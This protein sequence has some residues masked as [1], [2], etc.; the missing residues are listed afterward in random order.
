MS[1][2]KL[3]DIL[4]RYRYTNIVWNR[5]F[6][7][8]SKYKDSKNSKDQFLNPKFDVHTDAS[9]KIMSQNK[10]LRGVFTTRR[11]TNPH[12]PYLTVVL[13]VALS[14]SIKVYKY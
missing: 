4:S 10:R 6:D 12:L 13:T 7:L 14:I 11:Y 1:G 2:C 9:S 5:N 8:F 3:F